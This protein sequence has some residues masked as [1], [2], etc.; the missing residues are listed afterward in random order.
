[1]SNPGSDDNEYSDAEHDQNDDIDLNDDDREDDEAEEEEEEGEEEQGD[2]NTVGSSLAETPQRRTRA[3]I[4]PLSTS[5][6]PDFYSYEANM[7]DKQKREQDERN[8]AE[9]IE[10]ERK[11]SNSAESKRRIRFDP[12]GNLQYSDDPDTSGWREC[13]DSIQVVTTSK[14]PI[15]PAVFHHWIRRELAE[16]ANRRGSYG[17][18]AFPT[19]SLS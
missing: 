10:K 9:A 7:T 15:E 16:A 12:K 17:E 5:S 14:M 18:P 8:F 13:S 3:P 2:P 19:H 11:S 1:M 4:V 6:L